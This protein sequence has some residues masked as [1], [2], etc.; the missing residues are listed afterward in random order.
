[1]RSAAQRSHMAVYLILVYA[2]TLAVFAVPLLSNSGLGVIDL[3]LPGVAPF[4]LL[5]A[6]WL[7]VAAFI[8]IALADG[9][10]GVHEL[11]RRVFNLRVHP[12]WYALA[13]VLLPATALATAVAMSGVGPITELAGKPDLLLTAVVAGGL[14]AFLLINWWEEAGWTGFVVHWLQPRVGP[15]AASVLTTWLQATVH[16]PLVFVADGVTVGRVPADQIPFYLVALFVLP[17]PVRLVITWLYN[18]TGRSVPVV[19]LYHAGLGVATGPGFIPVIAPEFASGLVY[20]GFA[21]LAAAILIA[22]R[23]RLGYV[24]TLDGLPTSWH[25]SR[26][27][28]EA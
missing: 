21:V 18:A 7:A 27:S 12:G 2:A 6:I 20:A 5:L 26:A 8:T 17:I 24:A 25:F 9:R 1:M 23:G 3:D 14:V 22:T 4:V 28:H 15:M 13:I 11:R 16:L 19:G 10:D